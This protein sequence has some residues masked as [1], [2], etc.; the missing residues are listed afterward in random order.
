MR[1][2]CYL[3]ERCANAQERNKDAQLSA[4]GAR[5]HKALEWSVAHT[6]HFLVDELRFGEPRDWRHPREHLALF[7]ERERRERPRRAE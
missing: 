3:F 1:V 5:D 7:S 6:K 2:S 4:T